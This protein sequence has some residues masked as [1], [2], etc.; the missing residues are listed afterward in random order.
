MKKK[1]LPDNLNQEIHTKVMDNIIRIIPDNIK[2]GNAIQQN[3]ALWNDIIERALNNNIKLIQ[4]DTYKGTGYEGNFDGWTI[5]YHLDDNYEAEYEL[6]IQKIAK[7]DLYIYPAPIPD[8]LKDWN[9]TIKVINTI[10]E[11]SKF[12]NS[13]LWLRFCDTLMGDPYNEDGHNIVIWDIF[14]QEKICLAALKS[15]EQ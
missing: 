3:T 9:E 13:D 6:N 5:Y 4:S 7:Q 8:Y 11:K 14:D 10:K 15:I 2:S 1:D 12:C